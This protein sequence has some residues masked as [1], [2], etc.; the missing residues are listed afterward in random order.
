MKN[1]TSLKFEK[2]PPTCLNTSQHQME[3]TCCSQQC[4]DRLAGVL[5]YSQ[6]FCFPT[7]PKENAKHAGLGAE[8]NEEDISWSQ[9]PTPSSLPL[10]SSVEFSRFTSLV[11][12]YPIESNHEKIEGCEQSILC[13]A[14]NPLIFDRPGLM[15]RKPRLYK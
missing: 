12:F 1:L 6:R 5:D 2:T 3:A 9:S 14:R 10:R 4:C 7:H 8:A 15:E 11:Q 13:F